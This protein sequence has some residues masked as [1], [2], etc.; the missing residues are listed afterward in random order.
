VLLASDPATPATQSDWRFGPA[1]VVALGRAEA[2][3]SGS[4]DFLVM[5]KGSVTLGEFRRYLS[6]GE[7]NV[8]IYGD[9]VEGTV[10]EQAMTDRQVALSGA[11]HVAIPADFPR[12]STMMLT[13]RIPG[14]EGNPALSKYALRDE[15]PEPPDAE[16]PDGRGERR[17]RV[18]RAVRAFLKDAK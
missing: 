5:Q 6:E 17:R 12:V 2:I 7:P 15:C 11:V 9:I 16:A 13:S 1:G 14:E 18:A 4:V 8:R 3:L 10:A